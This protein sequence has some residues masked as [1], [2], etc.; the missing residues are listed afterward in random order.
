MSYATPTDLIARKDSRSLGDLVN[1]DNTRADETALATN[2]KL[3]AALDDASGEIDSALLQG[4]RYAATDLAALTGNSLALLK[5]ICCDIAFGLLYQR[6]P[7]FE[8]E[9]ESEIAQSRARKHLK[10]L[11]SGEHVFDVPAVEQ[12]GL[13][14]I[15][16]ASR[17]TIQ[18]LN[19]IVDQARCHYYP[20]RLQPNNR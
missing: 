12:A 16:G 2:T 15:T 17:V 13:P 19:M 6:R 7:E 8:S 10:M 14:E 11:R 20:P 9:E 1:D 5:R 3:Q 4:Q 18:N